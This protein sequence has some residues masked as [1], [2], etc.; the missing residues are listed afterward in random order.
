MANTGGEATH[1]HE[2]LDNLLDRRVDGLV[3]GATYHRALPVPPLRQADVANAFDPPLTTIA[4][5]HE[6]MGR[7]A[8]NRLL[9]RIDGVEDADKPELR[10]EHCPPV[11]RN[12]VTAPG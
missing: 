11:L 4:L 5:P 8:V 9:D 12:S 6:A 10:L 2:A 7:W 1:E 3:L